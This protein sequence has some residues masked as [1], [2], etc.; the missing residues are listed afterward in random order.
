MKPVTWSRAAV[1]VNDLSPA[2][3]ATL[4][5]LAQAT[6]MPA[7]RGVAAEVSE[8]RPAQAWCVRSQPLGKRVRILSPH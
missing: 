7:T 5:F 6:W 3:R 1:S 2:Q 8:L 4:V